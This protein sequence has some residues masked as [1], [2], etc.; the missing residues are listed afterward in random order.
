MPALAVR[1]TTGSCKTT[2][3]ALELNCKAMLRETTVNGGTTQAYGG[4]LFEVLIVFG[5]L[6]DFFVTQ[7]FGDQAHPTINIVMPFAAFIGKQ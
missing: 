1:P 4:G 3:I 5:D 6:L 7:L 2:K